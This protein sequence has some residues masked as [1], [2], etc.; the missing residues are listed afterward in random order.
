[1]KKST[2][3]TL[4]AALLALPLLCGALLLVASRA[5]HLS[6]NLPLE[7]K[8]FFDQ[9]TSAYPS[10]LR[11]EGNTLIDA[12]GQTVLLRGLMPPDP[13]MLARKGRFKR[14]F[15]DGMAG[16]GANVI[17]LPVHPERWERD[18]DYL[19]RYLDPAVAWNGEN[20]VY[21]I[22]DLHF[23]GDMGTDRG[24]QMPD[25]RANS[26]DFALDFWR[27][28]A[29]YFK[30]TP[31]VIFEI[32]NEPASISAAAWQANAQALV[33]VIRS[34]GARQ[35][36]IVGGIEYSRDLSWVL[37]TPI[38]D[39]DIAYAAH[40]YPAHSKSSWDRWFG[41]ISQRYPV[42]MTEWGWMESDPSGK[43]PYLVGSQRAYGEPLLAYLDQH[44]IGWVACW[45][46]DD[47]KPALFE[48]GI[49]EPTPLGQ[50]V[51]QRLA[52]Q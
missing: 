39:D 23:I 11:A 20:G 21:T 4:L 25:L 50:F 14:V 41:N 44:G 33:D 45:Y 12:N 30:D 43:Q 7:H 26:R 35:L 46:D 16:S 2:R 28:V 13:A 42:V 3:K 5:G 37:K 36:I 48:K 34:E 49:E 47:W 19:W 15:F 9:D 32:F 40:I 27:E 1:M 17:R 6:V 52:G 18:P 10:Q 51:L 24:A 29:A 38:R 22:I 31:H 8:P